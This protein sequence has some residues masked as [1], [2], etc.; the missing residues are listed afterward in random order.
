MIYYKSIREG[1]ES[2]RVMKKNK[3]NFKNL[4]TIPQRCDIISK[5]GKG[6]TPQAARVRKKNKK[7]LKKPL[8]KSQRCDI[9]S[10]SKGKR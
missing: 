6:M 8:T 10:M 9:M 5:Q 1:A 3:K 2:S 4:L 7:S